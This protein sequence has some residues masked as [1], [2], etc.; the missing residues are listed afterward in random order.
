MQE[1]ATVTDSS[2]SSEQVN[3]ASTA[4]KDESA[5]LERSASDAKESLAAMDDKEKAKV[6]AQTG[7]VDGGAEQ[8]GD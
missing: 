6:A 4:T 3:D 8:H 5:D 2:A 1:I 7:A